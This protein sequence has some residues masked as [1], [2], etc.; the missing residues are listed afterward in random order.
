[1]S[2]HELTKP[3]ERGGDNN[4]PSRRGE[5]GPIF[6]AHARRA[7]QHPVLYSR[8]GTEPRKRRN[9]GGSANGTEL[10]APHPADGPPSEQIPSRPRCKVTRKRKPNMP[11]HHQCYQ[12]VGNQQAWHE[13]IM[14]KISSHNQATGSSLLGTRGRRYVIREPPG[15]RSVGNITSRRGIFIS[16]YLGTYICDRAFVPSLIREA[17]YARPRHASRLITKHAPIYIGR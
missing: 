15:Y 10:P 7:G 12:L 8:A 1:L 3:T 11:G 6:L 2:L 4:T 14:F 5:Q 16:I 17:R 13:L 9:G